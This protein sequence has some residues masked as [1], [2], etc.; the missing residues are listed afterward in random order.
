MLS[1]P[2]LRRFPFSCENKPIHLFLFFAAA[3]GLFGARGSKLEQ[4]QL[5]A[6]R[7]EFV[8]Y[9]VSPEWPMFSFPFHDASVSSRGPV[10]P[11]P[12]PRWKPQSRFSPGRFATMLRLAGG[13]KPPAFSPASERTGS[14]REQRS[15]R[16]QVP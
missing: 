8:S 14:A 7:R 2:V 12:A 13:P 1:L 11:P 5:S 16:P 3:R 9:G 10:P 15:I 6:P 4:S